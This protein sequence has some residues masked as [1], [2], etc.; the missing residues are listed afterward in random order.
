MNA[1]LYFLCNLL[2][3]LF[4]VL[5][6]KV[7]AANGSRP[8][9]P[10]SW[11]CPLKNLEPG[12]RAWKY[13]QT[14]YGNAAFKGGIA[15]VILNILEALT[16]FALNED[17][18]LIGAAIMLALEILFWF[19]LNIWTKSKV[20]NRYPN[21]GHPSHSSGSSEKS[22]VSEKPEPSDP[23]DSSHTAEAVQKEP[24][25]DAAE[26]SGVSPLESDD[27]TEPETEVLAVEE[28][29]EEIQISDSADPLAEDKSPEANSESQISSDPSASAS[30][31]ASSIHK[32]LHAAP[33][34]SI[35][36]AAQSAED[37]AQS[38]DELARTI[39]KC[40]RREPKGKKFPHR[41][42]SAH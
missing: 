25:P 38:A 13:G 20:H 26:D 36:E 1:L 27:S 31:S 19:A 17:L 8:Y 9:T 35:R 11:S 10:G 16:V 24:V 28:S 33:T 23:A 30:S 12:S 22:S 32:D 40:E 7:V 41:S 6:G 21:A 34:P 14:V 4:F 42:A 18:V 2:L 3:S 5:K 15:L 29:Q 37:P 39:L